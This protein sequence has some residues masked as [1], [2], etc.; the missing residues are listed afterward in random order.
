MELFLK[1]F[2]R[3]MTGK[4]NDRKMIGP[5]IKGITEARTFY[6]AQGAR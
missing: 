3:K 5:K 6:R 4:S 1:D 2:I